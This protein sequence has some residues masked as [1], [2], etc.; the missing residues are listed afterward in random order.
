[1]E[2]LPI[3]GSRVRCLEPHRQEPLGRIDNV[4]SSVTP[5]KNRDPERPH[6]VGNGSVQSQL[7][8]LH[9]LW[10]RYQTPITGEE[11][12]R[13]GQE[14]VLLGDPIHVGR[15]QRDSDVS[16]TQIHIEMVIVRTGDL[17]NRIDERCPVAERTGVEAGV[18]R[19]QQP[20]PVRQVDLTNTETCSHLFHRATVG[21]RVA[22]APPPTGDSRVEPMTFTVLNTGPAMREIL[23]AAEPDRAELL[24]RALE[25]AAGMYSFSPGE[26]DLVHMHTMGSGFPLDRDIDLSMEGLRR[27]EEARAWERIGEALRE[28]TKVLERANPGVRVPDATVLLVLGDPTDEFFQTTSLGMNASD[29][30]PGYICNVRW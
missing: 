15:A 26:P 25:P 8:Y 28:A 3:A 18:Q 13:L 9:A 1:M 7:H 20:P 4:A 23:R 29:S 10:A 16:D 19:S 5:G 17:R 6:R 12:D 21:H 24:R 27:L 30:V 14:D 2:A 11:T 22:F